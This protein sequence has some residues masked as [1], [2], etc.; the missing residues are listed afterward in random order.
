M[1]KSARATYFPNLGS[2]RQRLPFS[3]ETT[4]LTASFRRCPSV[5]LPAAGPESGWLRSPACCQ[6][7]MS[8]IRLSVFSTDPYIFPTEIRAIVITPATGRTR[9][10]RKWLKRPETRARDI[11]PATASGWPGCACARV[12]GRSFSNRRNTSYCR[13]RHHAELWD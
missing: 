11:N 12:V 4:N 13:C 6:S 2:V 5:C 7:V 1:A 9:I 8:A 10:C 3:V